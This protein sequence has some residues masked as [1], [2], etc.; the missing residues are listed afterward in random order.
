[1]ANGCLRTPER[2]NTIEQMEIK[3]AKIDDTAN[4]TLC[5]FHLI[6]IAWINESRRIHDKACVR[7]PCGFRFLHANRRRRLSFAPHFVRNKCRHLRAEFLHS[8]LTLTLNRNSISRFC[9]VKGITPLIRS[10][11]SHFSVLYSQTTY[12]LSIDVI[13]N[14]KIR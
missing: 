5:T 6:K 8:R 4:G 3:Y 9:T 12:M 13:E 14:G 11:S 2:G 10:R 1:M 7:A